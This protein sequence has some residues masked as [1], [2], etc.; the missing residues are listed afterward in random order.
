[1]LFFGIDHPDVD[2]LYKDELRRWQDMGV[3]DVRLAC[4]Q[5]PQ[6][7]VAYVQHR[8][9]QDRARVS[10]LFQQGATVYVCG[11]G[12]HMAPA[13]RDTFVRIYRDSMGVSADAANAWADRMEREHGRYVA[14]IFS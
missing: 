4:S 10:A 8:M 2:Y 1:M 13:V 9:W 7:G 12:E 11:D 14:D 3:V 6:D 5:A